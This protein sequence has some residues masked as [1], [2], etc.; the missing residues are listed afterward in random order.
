MKMNESTG[1]RFVIVK[2]PQRIA[3][4]T[5]HHPTPAQYSTSHYRHDKNKNIG[6][7]AAV[8]LVEILMMAPGG[9]RAHH[10]RSDTSCTF[11]THHSNHHTF[12]LQQ[13]RGK[14]QPPASS[15]LPSSMQ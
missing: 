6:D 2:T 7:E 15:G 10:H 13:T 4:S 8:C 3:E 14:H 11:I 5:T 1:R 12:C 9:V